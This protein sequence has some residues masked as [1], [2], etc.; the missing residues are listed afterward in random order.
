LLTRATADPSTSL[1]FGRDDIFYAAILDMA[2]LFDSGHQ[3]PG[4]LSAGLGKTVRALRECP[5][6]KI[7][8]WGTRFC[9][10]VDGLPAVCGGAA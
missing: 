10:W 6:L 9:G 4:L 8:I 3:S 2:E 5:H 7:E 1:R